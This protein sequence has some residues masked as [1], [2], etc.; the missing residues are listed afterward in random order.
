MLWLWS[1]RVGFV[2]V[3]SFVAD[4]D[5]YILKRKKLVRYLI[6]AC[7][8]FL[9]GQTAVRFRICEFNEA[10]AASRVVLDAGE[11]VLSTFKSSTLIPGCTFLHWDFYQCS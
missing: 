8:N 4:S 2:I 5:G 9:S 6:T 11:P 1:L 10:T 3:A 7:N